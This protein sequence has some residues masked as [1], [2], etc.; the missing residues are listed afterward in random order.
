MANGSKEYKMKN[1]KIFIVTYR[2]TEILNKTL[3]ILFNKTDF[4][5]IPNTEVNIINNHSEFYLNPELVWN[6]IK[7]ACLI[8][9]RKCHEFNPLDQSCSI[10]STTARRASICAVAHRIRGHPLSSITSRSR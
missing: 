10:P 2:R 8:N 1:I 5:L 9:K 3:D 4:K 7:A 6:A